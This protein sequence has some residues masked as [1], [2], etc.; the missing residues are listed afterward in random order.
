[1]ILVCVCVCVCVVSLVVV[2]YRI[3]P[4]IPGY[5]RTHKIPPHCH[6]N[7]ELKA[8]LAQLAG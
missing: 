3:L 6:L 5:P 7:V 8:V 1:M 4:G 2:G